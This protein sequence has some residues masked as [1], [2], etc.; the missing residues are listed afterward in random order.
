MPV[1]LHRLHQDLSTADGNW[2]TAA[3]DRWAKKA[4]A[5]AVLHIATG[6]DG[7]QIATAD[8]ETATHATWGLEFTVVGQPDPMVVFL[9]EG[10]GKGSQFHGKLSA[11]KTTLIG[12]A[13]GGQ[14]LPNTLTRIAEAERLVPN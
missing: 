4:I 1:R 14:F 3:G 5:T 2:V 9:I 7:K 10:Y 11:D 13:S 12:Y 6:I 8:Y